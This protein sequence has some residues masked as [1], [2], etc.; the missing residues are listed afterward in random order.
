MIFLIDSGHGGMVDGKYATAPSKMHIFNEREVAYEG[1]IN[2]QI[3]KMLFRVMNQHHL[4]YIDI[5][6]TEMDLPLDLRCDITNSYVREYGV[7]N[8]LFVSLHSNAGGG[9]GVEI[10]TSLGATK[11]D[12]YATLFIDRFGYFFDSDIRIMADFSNGDVDKESNFYVLRNTRCPAILPEFLFFDNYSDYKK[13]T[14][15]SYQ[16]LY[17]DALASF[18]RIVDKNPL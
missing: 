9:D 8:C 11:S 5:C 14:N 16:S 10:W 13:L 15:V 3:K 12:A 4:K 7:E 1:V 18:F 6:P 17:V 2:R